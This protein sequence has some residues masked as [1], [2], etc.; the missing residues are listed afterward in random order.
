MLNRPLPP[1][2][3]LLM[4]RITIDSPTEMLPLRQNFRYVRSNISRRWLTT[5]TSVRR[6]MVAPIID[7]VKS[8]PFQPTLPHKAK[9][10]GRRNELLPRRH[11]YI[12]LT[13]GQIFHEMMVDHGVKHICEY[14]HQLHRQM[15]DAHRLVVGYPGGAV[16][17]NLTHSGTTH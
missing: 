8:S 13:G 5:D 9:H 4:V 17:M 6:A 1:F 14:S 7:P 12:G 15:T 11:P 10:V 16:S 3:S 2:Q